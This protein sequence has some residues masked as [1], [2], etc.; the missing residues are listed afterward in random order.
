MI[1]SSPPGY[2]VSLAG[3]KVTPSLRS[4]LNADQLAPPWSSESATVQSQPLGDANVQLRGLILKGVTDK[5]GDAQLQVT[6]T[7]FAGP[8]KTRSMCAG[9]TVFA[10][11]KTVTGL[12]WPGERGPCDWLKLAPVLEADQSRLLWLLASLI[13]VT[14]Q[15]QPLFAP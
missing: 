10:G 2:T 11:T 5:V 8:V 6:W 7:I 1:T 4:L 9:Q 15:V 12:A 14:K 13:T 3:V